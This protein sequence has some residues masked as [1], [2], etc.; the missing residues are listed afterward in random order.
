MTPCFM[1]AKPKLK[2]RVASYFNK[3]NEKKNTGN[4]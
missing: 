4:S 3:I 2:N 1:L